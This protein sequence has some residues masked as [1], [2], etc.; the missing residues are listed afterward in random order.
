M[1][2]AQIEPI[3]GDSVNEKQERENRCLPAT[4]GRTDTENM[5][6]QATGTMSSSAFSTWDREV[7][8]IG[9][10]GGRSDS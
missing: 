1:Q 2:I 9:R 3:I 10:G 6:T 8:G 5:H 7:S 4:M